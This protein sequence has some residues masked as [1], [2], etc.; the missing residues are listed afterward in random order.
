MDLDPIPKCIS[1][2]Q[3]GK[4]LKRLMADNDV[5]AAQVSRATGISS[6]TIHNW[7]SGQPPRDVRQLKK[8]ADYF[9]VT[10]DQLV[11]GNESQRSAL[12]EFKDE[13]NAGIFEVILRRIK[14]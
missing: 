4:I 10:L 6:R 12:E 14:K 1:G 9:K 7:L 13:I 11:F 8:V 3:L 2:M 5:N